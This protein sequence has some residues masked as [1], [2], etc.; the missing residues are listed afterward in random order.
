MSLTTKD[1]KC[2]L[3]EF[4]KMFEK[5]IGKRKFKPRMRFLYWG[6]QKIKVRL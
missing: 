6:H 4:E 5:R 2:S 3:E 1:Q